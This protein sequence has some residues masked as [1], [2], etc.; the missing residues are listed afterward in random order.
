M[1]ELVLLA[2]DVLGD[3]ARNLTVAPFF[4]STHRTL[5][6]FLVAERILPGRFAT[7]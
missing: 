3:D 6:H 7:S 5:G 2:N 4:G 1:N